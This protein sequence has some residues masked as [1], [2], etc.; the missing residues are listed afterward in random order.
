MYKI[1]GCIHFHERKAK[2]LSYSV[3]NAYHTVMQMPPHPQ[4]RTKCCLVDGT[5]RS[6][7]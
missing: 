7:S 2:L 4:C 5:D 3:P 6:E 1:A